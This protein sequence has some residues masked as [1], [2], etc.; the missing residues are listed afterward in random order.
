MLNLIWIDSTWNGQKT[1]HDL[2]GLLIPRVKK[3]DPN[4]KLKALKIINVG[5]LCAGF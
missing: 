5:M 4:V 3:S 1:C 2:V